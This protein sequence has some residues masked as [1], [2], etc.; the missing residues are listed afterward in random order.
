M[1]EIRVNRR[2]NRPVAEVFAAA[3]QA[4]RFA[5]VLPDVDKVTVLEDDGAGTVV[6]KWDGTV[7]LGPITRKISWTE[8]DV[9]DSASHTCTFKLIAGD[10]KKFDGTWK[11][12]EAGGDGDVTDA[13][14]VELVVDFEL[15]VPLLGPMVNKIV[16]QLMQHNCEDLLEGLEKLAVV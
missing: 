13:T 1:S 2:I 16:D 3:Q 10:M 6:T 12:I 5:D 8:R 15:G 14:D 11:F 9:W 4:E 7:S